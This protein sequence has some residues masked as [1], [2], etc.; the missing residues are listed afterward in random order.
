MI[1]ARLPS[2]SRIEWLPPLEPD[3]FAEYRDAA[4]LERLGLAQHA[5]A[6]AGFWPARGPQ[7]DALGRSDAGDIL[8]VE[9]KA[10]I[11]ELCSPG[12]K[13]GEDSL[14]R[15]KASLQ[16]T[17]DALGARPLVPWDVAFY[18]LGNRIAH[19]H[20]LREQGVQARLVLVNFVGDEDMGGPSGEDVWRGA[21]EVVWHIMGLR[22]R[23][24]M[25]KHI[26]E[27]FPKVGS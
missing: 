19:L 20:F 24:P 22:S 9:A 10:H 23:D 14:K 7:W 26:L 4:F 1:L 18:Q 13:A 5:E 27:V 16:S 8:L 25:S 17:I 12:S 3:G 21:Y 11:G 6:L 2:A 15:I